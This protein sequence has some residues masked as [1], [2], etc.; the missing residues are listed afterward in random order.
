MPVRPRMIS[1]G[2]KIW[3]LNDL[4]Q[5]ID[6]D[7]RIVQIGDAGVDDFAKI[8]RRNVRR[9]TDRDAAGTV[10]EQVRKFRRENGRLLQLTV[11]VVAKFNGFVIEVVKQK[12]RDLGETRFRVALRGRRI[13]ID[14][15]EIALTIDEWDAHRKILREPDQRIIDREIAVRVILAHHFADDARRLDVLLVPVEPHLVHCEQD[16]PVHGLQPVAHVGQG[17]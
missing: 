16:A 3:P 4:R 12:R 11:V 13:T 14:R 17:A 2:R 6:A 1:G 7:F 15:A 5:L 9:H 8:M 10:D